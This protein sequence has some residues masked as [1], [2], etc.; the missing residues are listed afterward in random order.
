M[1]RFALGSAV[2]LAGAQA[3]AAAPPP[4]TG[5]TKQKAL[6][7]EYDFEPSLQASPATDISVEHVCASLSRPCSYQTSARWELALPA[8]D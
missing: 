8:T 4:C 3:G 5:A 7:L 6:Y 1:A 2:I